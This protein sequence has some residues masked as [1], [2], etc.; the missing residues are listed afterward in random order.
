MYATVK[1]NSYGD[2]VEIQYLEKKFGKWVLKPG[3]LDSRMSN[4]MLLVEA[5]VDNR[6]RHT[7]LE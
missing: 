5:E 1:D 2:E 6:G 4:E 7:F 3:D